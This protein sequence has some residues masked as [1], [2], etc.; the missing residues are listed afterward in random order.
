MNMQMIGRIDGYYELLTNVEKCVTIEGNKN[1]LGSS[2]VK[3]ESTGKG[4]Y[5]PTYPCA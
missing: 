2:G 3:T 4:M 5:I 1:E